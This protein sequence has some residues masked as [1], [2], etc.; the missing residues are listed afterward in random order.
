MK[1]LGCRSCGSSELSMILNLGETPLANSLLREDELRNQQQGYP[2]ELV[3]CENCALV[4]ITETVDPEILF[5]NY[6]YFS[7][8]SDTVVKNAQE[9]V[10]RTILRSGLDQESLV[11]EIASNDGYLLQFYKNAGIPVLGIEPAQNIAVHAR[12]NGIP[13]VCEFFNQD[14]ANQ[15]KENGQQADVFHANNVLAHVADLNG[16]VA[17]MRT[18]LKP[19]GI[20]IIEF[21]Y[22]KDMIDGV[23]FDTIYHEHLCYYSLF[24]V[25]ALFNRHGMNIVDVE[26]LPIHGGSLRIFVGLDNGQHEISHNVKRLQKEEADWGVDQLK[27][28]AQF[29]EKVTQLQT[30][31]KSYL[32]ELKTSGKKLAAYGASAKGSTLLNTF[33]I[34][35]ETLDFV[36][37]RSTVKQGLFTPGTKIPIMDPRVLL[38]KK[39]DYVLLLTWNFSEEILSQQIQYRDLG[40]KF[41]IPIP[42]LH[43]V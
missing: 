6:V 18:L 9:I 29:G 12:A 8:F 30:E 16:V 38:E 40:G 42:V 41:I 32:I 28:Y 10:N 15:L 17:G 1:I 24:S 27:F 23:E 4:Q 19:D 20:G 11:V 26:R 3:F 5:R 7:S 33:G 2:L 14:V 21:P 13:T 43:T 22:V 34:G 36:V 25:K 37:D 39:P 31:L 35:S